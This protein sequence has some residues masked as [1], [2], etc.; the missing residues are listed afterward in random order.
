MKVT[1]AG[2]FCPL[3]EFQ[4]PNTMSTSV[5]LKKFKA[6]AEDSG[7]AEQGA[8]SFEALSVGCLLRGNVTLGSGALGRQL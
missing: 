1:H 5:L 7:G 8:Q 3:E 2:G 4:S 6:M